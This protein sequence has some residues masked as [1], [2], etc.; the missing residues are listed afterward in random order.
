MLQECNVYVIW[1]LLVAISNTYASCVYIIRYIFFLT[2]FKYESL[3]SSF[4]IVV[5]CINCLL[6]CLH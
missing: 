3:L 2:N 6:I 5:I 4:R 1:I